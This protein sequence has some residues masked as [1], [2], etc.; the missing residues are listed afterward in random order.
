MEKVFTFGS[1]NSLVG[2]LT[3][4]NSAQQM[5]GAPAVLLWNAGTLHRVGPYRLNVDTARKLASLGFLVFR[6]DISGKGDSNPSKDE[7]SYDERSVGDVREAMNFLSSKKGVEKFVLIGFCSGADEAHPVAL[8]D[9]RV[10]G[11]AFLDGFGY[12]TLGYYLRYYSPRRVLRFSAW[13]NL[14]KRLHARALLTTGGNDDSEKR[15][16]IFEREF[17]PLKKISAELQQLA[18]RGVNLLFVYSGGVKYAYFNHYG[19]FKT[20]F[21]AVDF[22]GKLRLEH[23]EES[24]HTYTRLSDRNKLLNCICEWMLDHFKS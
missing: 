4:P 19:Q 7:R 5:N 15:V 9:A 11:V 18:E 16:R 10:T 1:G 8:Q 2:I 22:Q 13:R 3:E 23:F 17:P 12:R 14:L 24:D 21:N 6:F 20:M